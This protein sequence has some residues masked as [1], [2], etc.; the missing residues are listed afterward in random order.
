MK[1]KLDNSSLI[2]SKRYELTNMTNVNY[3]SIKRK[4]ALTEY[5]KRL[6]MKSANDVLIDSAWL[7]GIC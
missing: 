4:C 2:N 1:R 5:K 7:S 6:C 3:R